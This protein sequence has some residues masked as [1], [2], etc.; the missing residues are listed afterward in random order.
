M[1][2]VLRKVVSE[3][4]DVKSILGKVALGQAEA[5][6]V[7]ATDVRPVADRVRAIAIPARAQPL[8]RYEVA[9]VTSS[10][11][12]AAARVWVSRLTQA[13]ARRLLRAAG[14]G[15]R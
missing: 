4:P 9:V 12:R 10:E 15:I 6:F 11:H 2:S 1:T 5:G 7:Y 14:F 8:V 3:E 13:R